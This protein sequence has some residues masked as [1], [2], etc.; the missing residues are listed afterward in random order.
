LNER[1]ELTVEEKAKQGIVQHYYPSRERKKVE[2][3]C[4]LRQVTAK[5]HKR[6]RLP[7]DCG[8]DQQEAS[9]TENTE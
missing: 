6:R 3:Y 5:R 9:L 8:K 7:K 4:S 1:E 2:K